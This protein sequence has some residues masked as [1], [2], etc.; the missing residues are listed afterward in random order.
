MLGVSRHSPRFYIG[1][2]TERH[3]E[4]GSKAAKGRA[5]GADVTVLDVRDRPAGDIGPLRE[6]ADEES[7]FLT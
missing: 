3:T 7:P 5:L 2:F 4:R 6:L 1:E